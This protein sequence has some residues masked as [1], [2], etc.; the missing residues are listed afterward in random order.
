MQ[1]PWP[2]SI[3]GINDLPLTEKRAIYHT[4]I[5]DCVFSIFGIDSES[6]LG[7]GESQAVHIR[8]PRGSSAVEISIFSIPG[9]DE[10]ALYLH[11]GDSF[12]SQLMVLLV[13]I[14]DPNSPRFNVDV[15]ERGNPNQLGTE[16][17][18]IPEELRAMRA[19]LAPGQVRGGLR[20][21][22]AAMQTFEDFVSNMG[23][24]I[25]LV[26]PLFYH[27]AIA[28]E[29]YGFTYSRGL[30]KMRAI[31]QG[32]QPGGE[33]H[34]RLTGDNPFRQPDAWKTVRGR[35]WAIHDGILDEAFRGIQ[36]YKRVGKD[37]GIRTFPDSE[38]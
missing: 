9:T 3:R 10:P 1:N 26:E 29:R 25:F 18:N 19:G 14:N 13:V 20:I 24:E 2:E 7:P 17:R 30:P 31:H 21:F 23:H 8:A 32:F 36:M 6:Y 28:F 12:N 34:A 16:Y 38:W 5:P 15:D 22:R 37:A 33:L 35:S 11:M 4:L 27:N